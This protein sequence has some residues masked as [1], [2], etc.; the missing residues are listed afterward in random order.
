M[1][2]SAS[3]GKLTMLFFVEKGQRDCYCGAPIG[4]KAKFCSCPVPCP[5]KKHHS[6][7]AAFPDDALFIQADRPK[8][9]YFCQPCLPVDNLNPDVDNLNDLLAS[10]NST[11]E[12]MAFMQARNSAALATTPDKDTPFHHPRNLQE[13]KRGLDFFAD[14]GTSFS[15]EAGLASQGGDYY[16]SRFVS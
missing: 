5:I 6:P 3:A 8:H 16:F 14:F 1:T 11:E 7:K 15:E 4:N 2:A 9:A 12:Y 10:R 13:I